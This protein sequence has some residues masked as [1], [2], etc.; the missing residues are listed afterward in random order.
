MTK[1]RAHFAISKS[2]FIRFSSIKT[3]CKKIEWERDFICKFKKTL[4]PFFFEPSQ[5]KVSGNALLGSAL[6]FCRG[7]KQLT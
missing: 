7:D 1:K 2:V 5:A 4:A 3:Y 6:Q